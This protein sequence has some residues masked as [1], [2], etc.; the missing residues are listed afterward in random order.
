MKRPPIRVLDVC[1]SAAAMGH[2]HGTTYA[3]EI[4]AYT[5]DR[6]KLVMSG[7]WSG[8]PL[9]C[10]DVIDIA[11]SCLPAHER[12]SPAL[13]EEMLAMADGAGITP[14][15]SVIV[16]G[17]ADFVDTVRATRGDNHPA[18]VI[19]DDCTAFIVPDHRADGAGFYGQTWD[20]HDSATDH[21]I[22]LR[23]RSDDAPAALVFTTTGCLGQIGM[24]ELGVCVGINNL[25]ANDGT[26]GVMW[27]SVV[28]DT[29]MQTDATAARDVILEAPLAG[30]HNFMTF[31]AEGVGYNI[32][33]MPTARPVT[34]L[35]DDVL[36]HTNH[37]TTAATDAVQGRR[38]DALQKSSH[39]RWE[40]AESELDR[41]GIEVEDLMALTR[42]G[43]CQVA[44]PPYHIESSGAAI[45]R[46]RTKEFWA[47]W[48]LPS[49]N[50]YQ[51]VEFAR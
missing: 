37:T 30:G 17:F 35:C 2:T 22:L 20:M 51:R 34:P 26:A 48:G 49:V 27:P 14:A 31:D 46:P 23:T 44:K 12:H 3:E 10:A 32:E 19:E 7:L 41:D 24:N 45:M 36:V 16:G 6:V 28:R 29:L 18:T 43:V 39:G 13:Y 15:E 5:D 1:G 4:R 33:A 38:A 11:A 47:V 21:V 42:E 8:G 25:T 50:D 40:I 9:D